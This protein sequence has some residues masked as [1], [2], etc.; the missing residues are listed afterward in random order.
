MFRLGALALVVV[1]ASCG[2]GG[3]GDSSK[4][5]TAPSSGAGTSPAISTDA[6]VKTLPSFTLPS[7]TLPKTEYQKLDATARIINVYS[8]NGAGAPIDVYYGSNPQTDEKVA[9]VEFATIT[10]PVP[11]KVSKR[12]LAATDSP[13]WE[14]GAVR[15]GAEDFKGL[16][17]NARNVISQKSDVIVVFGRSQD[18]DLGSST[19]RFVTPEDLPPPA[20]GKA[21]LFEI[22]LGIEQYETGNFVEPGITGTCFKMTNSFQYEVDAGTYDAAFFDANTGCA[23]PTG[24]TVK[25]DVK[26][27]DRWLLV[28]YGTSATDRKI[29]P[30]KV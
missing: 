10:D 5:S 11:L 26:A 15:A 3:S 9:T 22:D 17:I 24:P 30:I 4:G 18:N 16:L 27:G 12:E 28:G 2:G 1:A 20:A 8:N 29:L 7:F 23:A 21:A 19:I 14:L 6:G 25:L 13:A